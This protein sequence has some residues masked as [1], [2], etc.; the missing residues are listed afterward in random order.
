M[1]S[2]R[3]NTTTFEDLLKLSQINILEELVKILREQVK[4]G[5]LIIIEKRYS[6]EPTEVIQEIH[7]EEQLNEY[8]RTY[9][10]I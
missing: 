4:L 6:N 2:I 7:N 10:I 5:N 1:N 9:K 8:L 3:L